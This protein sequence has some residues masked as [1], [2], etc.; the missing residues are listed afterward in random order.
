MIPRRLLIGDQVA[1]PTNLATMCPG[2]HARK[3]MD[4]EPMLYR[5]DITA[6]MRFLTTMAATGPVP[7]PEFRAGAWERLKVLLYG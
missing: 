4:L 5:G 1:D 6:F 3:T 7:D 2:C